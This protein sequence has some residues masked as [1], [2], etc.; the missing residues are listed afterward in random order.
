MKYFFVKIVKIFNCN[1]KN[2]YL[3][4]LISQESI[5]YLHNFIY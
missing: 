5:L 4:F 1:E 3:L 2:W